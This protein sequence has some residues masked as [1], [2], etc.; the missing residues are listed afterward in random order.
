M[1]VCRL[2]DS[3]GLT[4]RVLPVFIPGGLVQHLCPG[5]A[6]QILLLTFRNSQ[7]NRK[8]AAADARWN[9]QPLYPTGF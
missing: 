5:G 2:K 9:R 6:R 1:R 4:D 7:G 3:V 8:E